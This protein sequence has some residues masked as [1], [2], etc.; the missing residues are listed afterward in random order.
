M[1]KQKFVPGSVVTA[2]SMV[3]SRM[4]LSSLEMMFGKETKK[5]RTDKMRSRMNV[6]RP[7]TQVQALAE[8]DLRGK[9]VDGRPASVSNPKM[10]AFAELVARVQAEQP[11]LMKDVKII[12][13][14]HL[15]GSTGSL[16]RGF[17]KLGA[18]PGDVYAMGKRYSQHDAV[19]NE[20]SNDGFH[21]RAA[22]RE[23][24]VDLEI[25]IDDYGMGRNGGTFGGTAE[26]GSP[27]G[28]NPDRGSEIER[29][30]DELVA[31]VGAKRASGSRSKVIVI[32]DGGDLIERI[33]NE[34]P[35]LHDH[36][37]AV[38]QTRKGI[39]KVQQL[40]LS[41]PVIDVAQTKAKLTY[42]SPMIGESI[43]KSTIARLARIEDAGQIVSRRILCISHGAVGAATSAALR[44]A[45]FQ[46]EVYDRSPA[47]RHRARKD[48]FRTYETL[49]E[50]L[51][52][53]QIV[54]GMTGTALLD[55][56]SLAKLPDGAILVNGASS[57]TEFVPERN[58]LL[59]GAVMNSVEVTGD[60]AKVFAYHRGKRLE[61]GSVKNDAR[62]A[63]S[64]PST[65]LDYL[66]PLRGV[67]GDRNKDK[68]HLL[69]NQGEVVNFDG[70]VDPIPPRYIQ[71]TRGLLLLGA[72]Q[73]MKTQAPGIHALDEAAQ[74][75]WV[76]DVETELRATSESLTQPRF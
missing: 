75:R 50:A 31:Q 54:V 6:Q 48:G 18:R 14:Q 51:S 65:R 19:M 36:I 20:L 23:S 12:A 58:D 41:F 2:G 35:E 56:A 74:Q 70:S 55:K 69:V 27:R 1:R 43:A 37:V 42:E 28:R 8:A 17:A 10:T 7:R 52:K 4:N 49:D 5:V 60:N 30:I 16:L 66:L 72:V 32:D 11:D 13:L 64:K 61:L 59:R 71:L 33:Q 68:Q 15:L 21:V 3:P 44:R 53:A 29:T 22:E 40:Q 39:R 26:F 46:V 67:A 45:G 25:S 38:E 47:A 73:A 76:G 63:W 57:A 62:L 34:H 9:T 24:E